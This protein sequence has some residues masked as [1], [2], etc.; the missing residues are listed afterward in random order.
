M[1]NIAARILTLTSPHSHITPIM[2]EL[3]WLPIPQQVDYKILLLTFKALHG[4]APCYLSE[5]LTPYKTERTTRASHENLL[6]ITDTRTKTFGDRAF[7]WSAPTLW[8]RLPSELRKTND[9][10]DF[11]CAIKTMLFQIAYSD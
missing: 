10:D 11:K 1:L 7:S 2:K 3:H 4:L 8:N 6:Q 5:L 9:L